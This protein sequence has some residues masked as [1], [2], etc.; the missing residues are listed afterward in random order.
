ML[1]IVLITLRREVIYYYYYYEHSF[2]IDEELEF[3]IDKKLVY[4]HLS[5][6][7]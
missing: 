4:G 7:W 1:S 6:K 5:I 2:I 3:Q